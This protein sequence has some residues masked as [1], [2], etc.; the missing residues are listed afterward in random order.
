MSNPIKAIRS[1]SGIQPCGSQ[2]A[3]GAMTQPSGLSSGCLS[4]GRSIGPSFGSI[5]PLRRNSLTID[6]AR[7]KLVWMGGSLVHRGGGWKVLTG[8]WYD[9]AHHSFATSQN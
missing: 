8:D 3:D 4:K 1:N 2:H 9:R 7:D 6:R 5:A